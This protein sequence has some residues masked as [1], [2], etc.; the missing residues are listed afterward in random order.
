MKRIFLAIAIVFGT[1]QISNAQ[2]GFG[3][4]AGIN[5]NSDNFKSVKDDVLSGAKSKTGYHAGIWLKFE[6]ADFYIRPELVYT[7]LNTEV[8]YKPLDVSSSFLANKGKETNFK[9]K[10]IDIPVLLGKQ[11]FGFANVF[12][13]PSFQYIINSEFDIKEL[14]YS[15][16]S[17]KFS[18]GL[19]A[20]AGV[21]F[22][23]LGIDLRWERG[24]SD[25]EMEFLKSNVSTEEGKV[26]FDNRINQIIIGLSYK[27]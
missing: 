1:F 9:L 21:E 11:L 19:Q 15:D 17:K 6:M 2:L 8:N 13:G 25:S 18:V 4:K 3:V 7:E 22:G 14:E 24:F 5:Y 16:I 27:F 23:N 26:K 20:G 12:F 10:K